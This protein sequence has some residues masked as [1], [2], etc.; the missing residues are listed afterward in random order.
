MITTKREEIRFKSGRLKALLFPY[1][2]LVTESKYDYC[3]VKKI[4]ADNPDANFE[5]FKTEMEI[6]NFNGIQLKMLFDIFDV[7][8]EKYVLADWTEFSSLLKRAY[9]KNFGSLPDDLQF[10]NDEN[11]IDLM[12]EKIEVKR[13]KAIENYKL[14]KEI[15]LTQTENA[16]VENSIIVEDFEEDTINANSSRNAFKVTLS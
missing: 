3:Y 9:N 16:K 1:T 14:S 7:A 8:Y 15:Y 11:Y 5:K 13:K 6:E 2:L 10:L 4:E 12:K